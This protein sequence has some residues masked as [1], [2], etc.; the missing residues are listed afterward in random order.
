MHCNIDGSMDSSGQWLLELDANHRDVLKFHNHKLVE[1]GY[2]HKI[3]KCE[4]HFQSGDGLVVGAF[5]VIVKTLSMV[6]L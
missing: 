5:S 4:R 1:S 6:C 3:L 2:L